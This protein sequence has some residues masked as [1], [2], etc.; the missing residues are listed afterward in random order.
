MSYNDDL[1]SELRDKKRN[2][3][4]KI[5]EERIR[6]NREDAAIRAQKRL[7]ALED[8]VKHLESVAKELHVKVFG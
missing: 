7:C 8:E 6:Q 4:F 1:E 5:R 2:L 3:L